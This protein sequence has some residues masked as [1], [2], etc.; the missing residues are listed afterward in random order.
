MIERL[1]PI[2]A[3]TSS[4]PAALVLTSIL[5]SLAAACMV[6]F[7][8]VAVVAAATLPRFRA[9]LTVAA[10]WLANQLVG[11]GLLGYPMTLSSF[12]WGAAIGVAA[13]LSL[14]GAQRVLAQERSVRS[15][16]AAF[17]LGFLLFEGGLLLFALFAG[18]TE[19]FTPA[20][21]SAI[22]INDALW[23][24]GLLLLH[25]VLARA[26][27]QIFGGEAFVSAK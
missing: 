19:T 22:L 11:F 10:L 7:V 24:A 20:I 16:A 3:S 6:P 12:A 2:R 21:V 9:F 14:Q 15:T 18:G 1:S 4:W 25:E 26:L 27:P 8:G 23:C 5:G 17:V 13:L